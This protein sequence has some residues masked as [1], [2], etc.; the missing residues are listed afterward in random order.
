MPAIP[1]ES[2][3]PQVPGSPRNAHPRG[4]DGTLCTPQQ[5]GLG[6]GRSHPSL[7]RINRNTLPL[8]EETEP[9]EEG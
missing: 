2:T 1:C 9:F 7:D 6:E 5:K 8:R 3:S 4:R